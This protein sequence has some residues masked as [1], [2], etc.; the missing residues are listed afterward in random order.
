MNLNQS[1]IA[2]A[3]YATNTE[4]V[5]AIK[6]I[7]RSGFEMKKLSIVGRNYHTDGEEFVVGLGASE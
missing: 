4:A 2:I 6:E 1:N 7:Q 5:S 3:I